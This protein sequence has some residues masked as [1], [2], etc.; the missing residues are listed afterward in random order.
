MN[1]GQAL[2]ELKTGRK[3]RRKGWNGK[4]IFIKMQYAL[5]PVPQRMTQDYIYIDTTGLQTDNQYAPRNRVPWFASQTDMLADDWE[6][7]D[8]IKASIHRDAMRKETIVSIPYCPSQT[9]SSILE[10]VRVALSKY[11]QQ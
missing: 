1:F 2:E 7:V 6:V 3:L 9:D 11:D 5:T 8:P 10:A 4:D